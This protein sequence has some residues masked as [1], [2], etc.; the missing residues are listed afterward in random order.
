MIDDAK[1]VEY[2]QPVAR[3]VTKRFQCFKTV[4]NKGLK[5]GRID[6]IGFRDVGGDLSGE[7][8]TIAVEVKLGGSTPFAL[9]SGQTLGY[10]VFANRV[11]LAVVRRE[12]ISSDEIQI[13]SNLG[14]GL[15][16]IAGKA[17]KEELSSPYYRPLTKLNL[18]LL[19]SV[20]LG[21]CQFAGASSRS[22]TP[23]R[24]A[25]PG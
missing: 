20:G 23:R 1:E 11:Y 4:T 19:E 12:P 13:A 14:I 25:S 18:Q 15:I 5:Y 17:C 10:R 24:I 22:V 16:R 3:W 7:I 8:E 9:A 2:Y 6:V 21:H